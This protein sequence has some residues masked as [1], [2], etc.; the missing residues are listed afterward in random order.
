MAAPDGEGC[1]CSCGRKYK[2]D[3]NIP[4]GIWEKIIRKGEELLCGIC[5]MQRIEHLNKFGYLCV[6]DTG[7]E[8]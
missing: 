8:E 5:I 2:F 4:D 3:L 6:N 1:T 7:L